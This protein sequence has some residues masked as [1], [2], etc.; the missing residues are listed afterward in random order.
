M[1]IRWNVEQGRVRNG[2]GRDDTVEC[3]IKEVAS[4]P[5]APLGGDLYCGDR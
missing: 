2:N 1:E 3:E 4:W 5:I